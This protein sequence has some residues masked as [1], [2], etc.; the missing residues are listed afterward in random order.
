MVPENKQKKKKLTILAFKMIPIL[1]NTL[2]A[3]PKLKF[4]FGAFAHFGGPP[5]PLQ[6]QFLWAQT[7][8]VLWWNLSFWESPKFKFYPGGFCPFWGPTGVFWGSGAGGISPTAL[9]PTEA[10][11]ANPAFWFPRSSPEALHVRRRERPLPVKEGIMGEKRPIKFSVA[12][13]LPH[14]YSVL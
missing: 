6:P 12:M 14:H 1:H 8:I 13:R 11:C 9:Q 10:Y 5:T 3:T 2:L 7:Q 4:Y